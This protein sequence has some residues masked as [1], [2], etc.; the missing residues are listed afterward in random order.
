MLKSDDALKTFICNPVVA[1][2]KKGAVIDSVAKE[3]GF[4]PMTA[5]F[6]KLLVDRQRID[7]I[8]AILEQFEEKYC[9][10]TNTQARGFGAVCAAE[11]ACVW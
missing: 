1:A 10:L 8:D 6:L 4:Q 11:R 2:D 3:A 9:K 7:S 5:N